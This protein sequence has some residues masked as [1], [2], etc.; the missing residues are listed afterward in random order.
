MSWKVSSSSCSCVVADD[1]GQRAVDPQEAAVERDQR[2]A[3][4]RLLEGV[5]EALLGLLERAVDGRADDGVGAGAEVAG[6]LAAVVEQLDRAA[7]DP[8]GRA[9][10]PH[11]AVL[12]G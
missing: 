8:D 5:G 9:V 2:H 10:A 3:D 1:L 7:P 11:V 4:R 6:E 12:A